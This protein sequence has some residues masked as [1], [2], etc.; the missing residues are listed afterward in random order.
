MIV[1]NS[2]AEERPRSSKAIS[3][4]SLAA[5]TSNQTPVSGCVSIVGAAAR[6]ATVIVVDIDDQKLLLA[7]KLGGRFLINS[8]ESDLHHMLLELTSGDGPDVVVEAAGNP[9]TYRAAVDE[10][11]FTGR[12]VYIGYAGQEVSFA[13]KLFVQ[14]ELDILGSRNANAGDFRAVIS[15]LEQGQF[16]LDRMITRK[17]QLEQAGKAVKE[18]A[19]DPGKVMKILLDMS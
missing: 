5:S 4:S 1:G 19:D 12:V 17:V 3:N 2:S 7:K 15:Y 11:A 8:K 13:T 18:W 14:K 10:V 16:P 9:S 6:G